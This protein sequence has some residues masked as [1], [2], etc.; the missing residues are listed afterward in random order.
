MKEYIRK[1]VHLYLKLNIYSTFDTA[2]RI[3]TPA[4]RKF[5][6]CICNS[7]HINNRKYFNFYKLILY[8]VNICV[9]ITECLR[10]TNLFIEFLTSVAIILLIYQT[11]RLHYRGL[12]CIIRIICKIEHVKLE[13][14]L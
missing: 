2:C 10:F 4:S 7:L 8:Y 3:A 12:Y 14:T 9:C 6:I 13:I 5:L 11:T 1:S